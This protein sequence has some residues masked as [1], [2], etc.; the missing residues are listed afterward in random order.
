[1]G[2]L[3]LCLHGSRP[4]IGCRVVSVGFDAE[5]GWES[6]TAPRLSTIVKPEWFTPLT[7]IQ[8]DIT[9]IDFRPLIDGSRRALVY[10]DARGTD[11]AEAVLGRLVP[12]LPPDNQI[13]VDD[14]WQA[15]EQYGKQAE[16]HAGPMWSMFDEIFPLWE[17]LTDRG[18]EFESGNR[19]IT[20]SAPVR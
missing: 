8:D 9:T 16:Y 4:G 18:I 13:V 10:W 6:R 19:Y 1:M 20:F 11:V 15:P 5:H 14:G 7:V 3:D 2:Q 17:Y 12:S